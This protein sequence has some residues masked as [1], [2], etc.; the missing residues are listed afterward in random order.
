MKTKPSDEQEAHWAFNAT[1]L[2]SK[3]TKAP[4]EA[5][6]FTI[7]SLVLCPL[8]KVS[9]SQ[10]P[11]R[12]VWVSFSAAEGGREN[13]CHQNKP[14]DTTV[15]AG[16]GGEQ[17]GRPPSSPPRQHHG[18]T[19]STAPCPR[20]ARLSLPCP[21]CVPSFPWGSGETRHRNQALAQPFSAAGAERA[22]PSDYSPPAREGSQLLTHTKALILFFLSLLPPDRGSDGASA[23]GATKKTP[24]PLP[25]GEKTVTEVALEAI[26][27][28]HVSPAMTNRRV[29]SCNPSCKQRATSA[30]GSSVDTKVV[31]KKKN[32]IEGVTLPLAPVRRFEYTELGSCKP[33]T[34]RSRHGS[35]AW[36]QDGSATETALQREAVPGNAR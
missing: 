2:V 22:A 11:L 6:S 36:P 28:T 14:P 5:G 12:F 9:A 15:R 17:Q 1:A 4:P 19:D 29:G 25:A 8:A 10:L 31:K 32:K 21:H 23:A 27:G 3:F 26:K 33:G 20:Q 7:F 13:Q 30:C 35:P 16:L 24:L 34:T 18:L